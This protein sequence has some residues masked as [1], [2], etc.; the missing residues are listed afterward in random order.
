MR[1]LASLVMRGPLVAALVAAACGILALLLP[2]LV[3]PS[4]AAVALV[5]LR[6][7]PVQ[8]LWVTLLAAVGG[9]LL[10]WLAVGAP[11]LAVTLGLMLWLPLLLL[12]VVLRRSISL[13]LTLQIAGLLGLLAVLAF[14]LVLGDPAVWWRQ[15][16]SEMMANLDA[17]GVFPQ[18][19]VR[20]RL[21]EIFNAW[22]PLAPGQLVFSTLLTLLLALLLARW[23][24]AALYNP[25]G[26][27]QE[28]HALR[29]G[30]MPATAM[31]VLLGL[32]LI[33]IHPLPINLCLALAAIYLLQGL[34]LVHGLVARAGLGRVWLVV[35]YVGLI[36]VLALWQLLLILAVLDA[37][38]DFRARLKPANR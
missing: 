5:T 17:A 10:A 1:G 38:I 29:L 7:G 32:S 6:R 14:Y 37:W 16:V 36:L 22:A 23:W 25:G 20:D 33:S 31:A 18:P 30:R 2:P 26:F 8:G 19:A 34:A 13:A 28:F 9:G 21:G 24:Q 27:R 4:G 15:I 11:L 3:I 12:A 35:F